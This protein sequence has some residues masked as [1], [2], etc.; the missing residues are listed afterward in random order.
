MYESCTRRSAGPDQLA[1]SRGSAGVFRYGVFQAGEGVERASSLSD[2]VRKLFIF[3]V[4]G[5]L[6]RKYRLI[7]KNLG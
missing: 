5:C 6:C 7:Y 3:N 1:L 2:F 4:V